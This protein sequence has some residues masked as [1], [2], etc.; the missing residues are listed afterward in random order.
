M[1]GLG[2]RY[3]QAFPTLLPT[4]YTR[5][6]FTVRHT[7]RQRTQ[8]SIRGFFDGLFG[9]NGYQQVFVEPIPNPDRLLRP[10]DGCPLYDA[11]IDNTVQR[12]AWQ[13]GAEFQ[14]M[15]NQ[16][17]DKLGLLGNQRLTPRQLRTFCKNSGF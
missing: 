14:L 9:H 4:F 8:G 12:A 1:V 10:L 3:Q 5:S 11:V 13:N 17:N 2:R 6:R 15:L 7:D 16:V